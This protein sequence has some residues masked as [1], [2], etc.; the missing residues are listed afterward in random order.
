LNSYRNT[1]VGS[2]AKTTGKYHGDRKIPASE[3]GVSQLYWALIS[4][5]SINLQ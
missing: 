3:T 4:K 1:Q 2:H 5:E